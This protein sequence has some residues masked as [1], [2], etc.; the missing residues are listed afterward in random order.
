VFAACGKAAKQTKIT[1][2][3]LRG[4]IDP[5]FSIRSTR[6]WPKT[7]DITAE[8]K[9]HRH[10]EQLREQMVSSTVSDQIGFRDK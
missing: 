4:V 2:Y 6:R 1:N 5:R 3:E 7:V 8:G 10:V 9:E